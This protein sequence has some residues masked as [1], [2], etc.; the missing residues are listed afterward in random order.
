MNLLLEHMAWPEVRAALDNGFLRVIVPV[1]SIEQHGY[2]LPENTDEVLGRECAV[3]TAQLLGKTLVAPC[4]RPGISPHHMA[5]PGTVTFRIETFRM[6]LEDYA[7]CYAR[8]GF[9]EIVFLASHGGNVHPCREVTAAFAEKYPALSIL[10]VTD[11]PT[12]DELRELECQAGL[13]KGTNGGHADERETSEM[14][15]AVSEDVR[16]DCAEAGFVG[17]LS[18]ALLQQFFTEGVASLTKVGCMGDPRA[19]S[20]ERGLWYRKTAA[21][22]AAEEIRA[23]TRLKPSTDGRCF[24]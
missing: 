22:K 10:T 18:P 23:Q 4:V 1:A 6:I 3:M 20:A 12:Q 7:D 19:A 11:V 14:L 24:G 2:H 17:V 21:Q 15:S 9:R 13:P 5:M 8:H 16:M